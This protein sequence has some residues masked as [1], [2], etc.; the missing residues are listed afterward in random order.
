[1]NTRIIQIRALDKKL[2]KIKPFLPV[3]AKNQS[4]IRTIRESLGMTVKQL[5]SRLGIT[6]GRVSIMEQN[7]KNMKIST[8]EKVAAAMD[9]QFVPLFIP[10]KTLEQTVKNQAE[11]KAKEILANVNQNMALENQLST[12][13]EI[14]QDMIEDYIHQNTKQ[15]WS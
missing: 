12:E 10:N 3:I 2:L 15:I 7:E 4:W 13:D 8:L 9:C 1:M 6:Q 14:L 11:K 5:A